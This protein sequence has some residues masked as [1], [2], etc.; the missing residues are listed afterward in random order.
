MECAH[1]TFIATGSVENH[2]EFS[3]LNIRRNHIEEIIPYSLHKIRWRLHF[4]SQ[5]FGSEFVWFFKS[6]RNG[7]GIEL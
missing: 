4:E 5:Q 1:C 6:I 2:N 3:S 7:D